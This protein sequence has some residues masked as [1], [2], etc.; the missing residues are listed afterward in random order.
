MAMEP[1]I[2]QD[3]DEGLL[4][5]EEVWHHTWSTFQR[6]LRSP[7]EFNAVGWLFR[8]TKA[9]VQYRYFRSGLYDWGIHRHLRSAVPLL[10]ISLIVAVVASYF[11]ILRHTTILP[12]WCCPNA[13]SCGHTHCNWVMLHDFFVVYLGVM[14]LFNYV[15]TCFRS[16]GVALAEGYGLVDDLTNNA[17]SDELLW[18]SIDARGGCCCLDPMIDALAEK[19]RVLAYQTD[20]VLRSTTSTEGVFP[21]LEWT[22]CKKCRISRPPRC[23]HCRVCNRCILRFD[24]HCVWV[25][26]CIGQNNYRS[27]L[28]MLVFLTI[29]CWYGVVM[30]WLPFY[31]PLKQQILE[32]GFHILYDNQTGFLNLPM[33]GILWKQFW[34]DGLEPLVVVKLVFPLLASVGVLEATLLAYHI[35]YTLLARTTLE[36][37]IMLD[38]QYQALVERRGVYEVP[39]NP[40]DH[41]WFKNLKTVIG[42]RP[43]LALLPIPVQSDGD[44]KLDD[45]KAS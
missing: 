19:R 25:N 38:R 18:K 5:Y 37:K 40:F 44:V 21:S 43:I 6:A 4:T 3:G 8:L 36:Y 16:P 29:G 13:T 32:H 1:E 33:P 30:L 24:H 15:A 26:N 12:R 11:F 34:F 9:Y 45:K 2:R 41:G 31:E 10:G 27:F 39:P 7:D 14:I 28:L 20:P 23:H 22:E 35:R 17:L 42:P